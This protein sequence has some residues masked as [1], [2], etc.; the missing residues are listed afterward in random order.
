VIFVPPHR[1]VVLL[2]HIV[3]L[4]GANAMYETVDPGHAVEQ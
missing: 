1:F 3:Y 2:S 4:S